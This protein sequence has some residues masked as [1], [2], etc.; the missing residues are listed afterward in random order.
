MKKD[1]K[2]RGLFLVWT[3]IAISVVMILGSGLLGL[4]G[5]AGRAMRK[6]QNHMDAV[7]LGQ[8]MMETVK[9]NARLHTHIP[10]P[11]EVVRNHRTFQI[12]VDIITRRVDGMAMDHATVTVAD[13][14]ETVKFQSLL[15]K[16]GDE[17]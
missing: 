17:R 8:E 1:C 4:T 15:G 11:S 14:D 3:T 10:L 12:Q 16:R 9:S 5:A 7:L 13:G 2:R 6:A